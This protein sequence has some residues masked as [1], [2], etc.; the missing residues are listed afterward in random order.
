M[1]NS[2]S[3]NSN[4]LIVSD[5][6]FTSQVQQQ[7]QI[8]SFAGQALN[9][10]IEK[11]KQKNYDAAIKDFKRAVGIAP[12]SSYATNAAIYM[13]N[14]YINLGDKKSALKSYDDALKLHHNNDTLYVRKGHLLF[15]MERYKEAEEAYRKAVH[16][17]KND[18]SLFSLGQALLQLDRFS[19]AT[20]AFQEVKRLAP[21][22]VNGDYGLALVYKEQGI[23]EKAVEKFEAITKVKKDFY[24]AYAEL[25][26]IYADLDRFDKA[27]E[28]LQILEE[29]APHLADTLSRYIYKVEEPKF[30][31]VWGNSTFPKS[32]PA[33]TKVSALDSYLQNGDA[34][35]EFNMIFQFNKEMEKT[36]VENI[37]NWQISRSTKSGAGQFYNFGLPVADTEIK[38]TSF[39]DQVVYDEKLML[40]T[41]TFTI[42]QNAAA[43][44]TIDPGH[45]LFKFNGV[46]TY[47]NKIADAGDE[48]SGFTGVI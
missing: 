14:S 8:D 21:N 12:R 4:S 27:E 30:M 5:F 43:D 28:M 25:G 31:F 42:T 39:P 47:G 37:F 18:V 23:L 20:E 19:E 11:Y 29:N 9:S 38:I 44:G 26:Y 36:S 22:S 3:N 7:G 17:Y 10:G 32:L 13:A 2:I 33:R 45:I 6:L 48:Y 24:D 16:I 35:K 46:D 41:L 1:S 34:S 40:A 15:D